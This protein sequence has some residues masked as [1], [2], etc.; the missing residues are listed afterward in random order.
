VKVFKSFEVLMNQ[1]SDQELLSCGG[2][3]SPIFQSD[4]S[5]SLDLNSLDNENLSQK[6]VTLNALNEKLSSLWDFLQ[7]KEMKQKKQKKQ[8]QKLNDNSIPN[9]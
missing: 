9:P 6:K 2:D 5:S 1:M 4:S 8:K 7:R 3:I